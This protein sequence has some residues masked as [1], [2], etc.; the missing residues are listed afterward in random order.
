MHP[1]RPLTL[2]AVATLPLCAPLQA[3]SPVLLELQNAASADRLVV[4]SAGGMVVRGT[5]DL[6]SIPATGAGVRMMWYPWK[7][8]FR[9]GRVDGTQ[10]DDWNVGYHS[11][12]TGY[13]TRASGAYSTAMGNSTRAYGDNSTAMGFGS[14]ASSFSTAMGYNS[15]ASG[16]ASTAMGW[17]ITASGFYSTA[18]G[19]STTA[20]GDASTAMGYLTSAGG[21]AATAMGSYA[22]TQAYD[23][24][25]VYGDNSTL[26]VMNATANHQFSVRASGGVRFFT[27]STLTSGVTLAAGGGTWSAVSDRARKEHFLAV[28]G[29]DVLARIRTL[30]ITT[31]RYLAEEDRSVRHIGPMAQD[32]H[33]AFGFSAD[34]LH[35]NSGDL[36]GVNLAGVQALE[37]RTAALRWE[38]EE[39][40]ARVAVVEQENAALRAAMTGMR[41][42]M[43]ERF[44]RLE[45]TVHGS[46]ARER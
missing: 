40:R 24:A 1:S 43:E 19:I 37:R 27:N 28:D 14:T 7:A 8:A 20:S 17:S 3:Q 46:G 39:L 42:E 16:Q 15:T 45:G 4:D 33:R 26:T 44:R 38:N 36:D 21:F 32:W 23:G 30:P 22:S 6:G 41:R 35:I 34:S 18:M 5:L 11:A 31:W 9:A 10:W 25:F 29:E 2:C 12:A 13:N